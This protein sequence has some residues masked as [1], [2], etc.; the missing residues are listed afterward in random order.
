VKILFVDLETSPITAHT[1][2]LWQQNISIKQILESTEVICFGARW[3]GKKAVT[4]RSVH[5]D[6]RKQMLEDLHALMEEADAIVGWNSKSFDHKHI[7]REFLEAG[8]LPPSPSKDID[9][10]LECKRNFKFPSYKLDYVA[11]KLGVGAKVEH[12]G[13]DLWLGCMA[14]DEKSWKMMKKYQL[15]DVNLLVDLYEILLPWI[16]HPNMGAFVDTEEPVCPNC[17][18]ESIKRKG[19]E[20]LSAGKYQRFQCNNCGKWMRGKSAVTTVEMR[21][22]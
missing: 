11:Q 3:Y 13:F 17:G 7:R 8:M 22:L 5:H 21:A 18:S 19:Y 14:G 6:G 12:T 1:W 10:M 15:Q 16:K 20:T 2:G 9:L 4:F